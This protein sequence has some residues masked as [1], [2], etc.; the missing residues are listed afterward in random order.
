MNEHRRRANI[1][2]PILLCVIV[3]GSALNTIL[4]SISDGL[5]LPVFLD[6]IFT[7]IVAACLGPLPGIAVGFLSNI[8]QE[9]TGG[10]PGFFWPFGFVNALSAVITALMVGKGFANNVIGAFWLIVALT[11]ANSLVG[12]FIVTLLFGGITDQPVDTIVRSILVTGRDILT[13]A[14]LG[15]VFINVVDKGIAVLLMLPVLRW[16]SRRWDHW[17]R[18]VRDSD[19]T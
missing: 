19:K 17:A 10:F 16:Y 7:V 6:S 18:A 9:V 2:L 13:A 3:A 4:Y 8:L 12:A 14:F 15:R 1:S 11:L 5:K